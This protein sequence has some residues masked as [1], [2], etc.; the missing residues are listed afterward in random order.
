M[1]SPQKIQVDEVNELVV[2]KD[3]EEPTYFG[4]TRKVLN[5]CLSDEDLAILIL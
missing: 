5:L 4:R 1:I 3:E 2:S